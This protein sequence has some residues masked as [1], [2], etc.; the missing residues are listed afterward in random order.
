MN[1]A[2][3]EN[4]AAAA[5]LTGSQLD[6]LASAQRASHFTHTGTHAQYSS[7]S[8][9]EAH[10]HTSWAKCAAVTTAAGLGGGRAPQVGRCM[11]GARGAKRRAGSSHIILLL[12]SCC[13]IM[14]LVSTITLATHQKKST[15]PPQSSKAQ[16]NLLSNNG[17]STGTSHTRQ[18]RCAAQHKKRGK[19]PGACA[20]Q[21][22]WQAGKAK[23]KQRRS[24]Q[25][26]P[27]GRVFPPWRG[28][29]CTP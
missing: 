1:P 16:K 14:P 24:L 13:T 18:T 4:P 22:S 19:M 17:R 3:L 28:R 2:A 25:D 7:E 21:N 26:D 27:Y 29:V 6:R 8:L 20:S 9:F 5:T 23:Y 10:K 12:S 11:G 15:S